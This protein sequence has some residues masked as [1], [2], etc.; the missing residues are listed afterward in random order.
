MPHPTYSKHISMQT[1]YPTSSGISTM[2]FESSHAR[3]QAVTSR[4]R[5]A[6]G[7]F[8]YAVKSTRIYCRPTCP[9]RLARR[10]NVDFYRTAS[11]ANAAGY[12]ACKRCKPENPGP[13]EDGQGE[14]VRRACDVLAKW[15]KDG[16]V[17]DD[18]EGG[19]KG[20]LDGK[21]G[22]KELA[23]KVGKTPRYLHKIFKDRMGVTPKQYSQQMRELFNPADSTATSGGMATS[24]SKAFQSTTETSALS[25]VN[26][27]S[28]ELEP[29]GFDFEFD[30]SWDV[31]QFDTEHRPSCS[32]FPDL[33]TDASFS[34]D[35]IPTMPTTPGTVPDDV[36]SANSMNNMVAHAQDLPA[37]SPSALDSILSD[38]MRL[39]TKLEG[40]P[41][42][43]PAPD[44]LADWVWEAEWSNA[45]VDGYQRTA[46][47][48]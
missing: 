8:V 6:D 19:G 16:E 46:A 11:D 42:D 37:L 20:G 10:A 24:P 21:M 44:G 47:I 39:N 48:L 35:R 28:F 22:L 7:H 33:T 40:M 12:R 36:V 30:A 17:L 14:I 34:P 9:A 18:V 3:W 41:K 4:L 1:F 45:I 25:G 15:A 31:E 13:E 38:A 26:L 43:L 27:T 29:L 5:A 23:T 2:S 32:T